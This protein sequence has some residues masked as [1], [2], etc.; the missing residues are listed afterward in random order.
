MN[1]A[2]SSAHPRIGI[3]CRLLGKKHAGIGRYIENLLLEIPHVEAHKNFDWVFI[4]HDEQQ[5]ADFLAH[6]TEKDFFES[7]EHLFAPIRHYSLQEQLKMPS[8]FTKLKLDLLHVPHFNVP[9]RY[10]GKLIVTIHDLLW[11]EYRGA[12]VTTLP[13]WK[14]WI[15]HR[16]YKKVVSFA[17]KKSPNDLRPCS[18]RQR[19]YLA[20]LS[21]CKKQNHRYSR[22]SWTNFF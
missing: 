18:N 6:T 8:I 12:Q 13:P 10:N 14:Y 5:W 11:H 19:H 4:F 21:K 22:G 1:S 3:D 17:I 16:M 20:I 7:Q 2:H 15:K 9:I